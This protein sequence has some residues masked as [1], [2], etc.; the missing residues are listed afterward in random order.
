MKIGEPPTMGVEHPTGVHP[1]PMFGGKITS[2]PT[3][4]TPAA[5]VVH[6]P[7]RMGSS[8]VRAGT[9]LTKGNRRK[10]GKNRGMHKL[11]ENGRN[12]KVPQ[13]GPGNCNSA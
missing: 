13:R 10:K 11:Q 6:A 4:V 5:T 3:A 12:Y 7:L 9:Y 1:A 2:Q 8:S